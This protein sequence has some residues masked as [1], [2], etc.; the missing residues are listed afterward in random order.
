MTTAH[1]LVGDVFD[2]LPILDAGSVDLVCTSPPFLAL[3][4]YLDDEHP[5]RDREIGTESSP[6]E[7]LDTLLE[8]TAEL[9]RVLARTGSLVV[10]LGDTYAGSGGAGGDYSPGGLR[11]GQGKSSGSAR[12]SGEWPLDKSLA[13]IPTLYAWS[14]AYGRNLLTGADSPAGRWIVRNVVAWTR[15]NPPVGATFDKFRPATSYITVATRAR[16]RWF[17]SFAVQTESGAAP[18]DWWTVSPESYTGSHYATWPRRLLEVPIRAMCPLEVCTVCAEPRRRVVANVRTFTDVRPSAG[19]ARMRTSGAGPMGAK[20]QVRRESL[21]FTDCGHS[22]YRRG[23]VLDPFAGSGTTGAVA[24]G[25]GLDAVLIDIDERNVELARERIGMF[26]DVELDPLTNPLPVVE[27][28][29]PHLPIADA[30]TQPAVK[31]EPEP[32]L[33]VEGSDVGRL[34]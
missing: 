6:A 17:D 7:F 33:E 21:G 29:S 16:D 3:R 4:R 11:D 10:E 30:D 2:V 23:V 27:G 31:V 19:R 25:L 28:S 12:R 24:T 9:G 32:L 18:L 22:S 13:G 26:L 1:Y 8:L 15:S 5:M 34:A 20:Y 14:L